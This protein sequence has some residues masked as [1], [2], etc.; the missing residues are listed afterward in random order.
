MGNAYQDVATEKLESQK[1]ELEDRIKRLEGDIKAPLD[2]SFSEQAPQLS[3]RLILRRLLEVER[4][5]LWGIYLE[6]EKRRRSMGKGVCPV[7]LA[8]FAKA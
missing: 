6:L 8:S 7:Q 3:N 2:A 1:L 4:V 5:N